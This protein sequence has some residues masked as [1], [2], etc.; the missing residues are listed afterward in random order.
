KRDILHTFGSNYSMTAKK[1]L[2]EASVWLIPIVKAY[3]ALMAD[4]QRLELE[5]CLVDKGQNIVFASFIQP[6]SAL[7]E[8]VRTAL[9]AANNPNLAIPELESSIAENSANALS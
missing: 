8:D 4:L 3:P 6:L 2:F 9:R 1:L 5:N 7:V